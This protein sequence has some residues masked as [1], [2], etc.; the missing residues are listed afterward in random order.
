MNNIEYYAANLESYPLSGKEVEAI[1]GDGTQVVSYHELPNFMSIEQLLGNTKSAILLYE[2]KYNVG[3]YCSLYFDKNNILHF[4]DP[5]GMNPDDPN[6][7]DD[8]FV[9]SDELHL[10]KD[11]PVKILL[12]S[13]DVL[14][15]YYVPQFRSKMD[16]VPGIVT[17]YWFEPNKVGE[18]EVLC[19]EYCG[20]GHYAMRGGVEVQST[21]D[22]NIWL[23]EQETFND[24]IAKQEIEFE[25]K[26]LVKNNNLI[27][28][29]E[30]YKEE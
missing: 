14:H 20:V 26:K 13:I 10:A 1:C 9:D 17:F 6:G 12:R 3:H 22:Y 8:V 28:N 5:Y 18:Y 19:A 7:K 27:L 29:K 21:E 4:F 11:R 25:N 15:N 2:T 23:S 24:L 30:I 16:A